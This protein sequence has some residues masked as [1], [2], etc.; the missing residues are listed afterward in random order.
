MDEEANWDGSER[1]DRQHLTPETIAVLDRN[2]EAIADVAAAMR[3]LASALVDSQKKQHQG[4]R[5]WLGVVSVAVVAVL[6]SVGLSNRQQGARNFDRID[7]VASCVQVGGECFER[8]AE[9]Q[10]AITDADRKL[11]AQEIICFAYGICPSG[12]DRDS[13]PDL[14]GLVPPPEPLS[15]PSD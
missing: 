5:V 15:L 14:E 2:G 1:R 4:I 6:L 3:E 7:E 13:I 10:K 8:I 9:H 11:L 12:M